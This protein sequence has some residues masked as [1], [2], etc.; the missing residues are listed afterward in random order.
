MAT[1]GAPLSVVAPVREALRRI[2]PEVP[3][4]EVAIIDQDIEASLA[5]ER[6]VAWIAG[7]FGA[8]A[9]SIVSVGLFGLLSYVVT[10]RTREI[11]IRIAVG[12]RPADIFQLISSQTL[13]LTGAG[14]TGGLTIAW[15]AS[16]TLAALLFGVSPR[17]PFLWSASALFVLVASLLS[18]SAP[19][20]RAVRIEPIA[21]LRDKT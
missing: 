19:A 15:F 8:I 3:I 11:G 4:Y 1:L 21:A 2:A 20:L 16:E 17:E 10:Q 9:L 14:L 13:R 12:A 18:T 6:M 7:A 5:S